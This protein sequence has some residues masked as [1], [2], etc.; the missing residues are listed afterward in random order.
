MM[1]AMI[2]VVMM[3]VND[4]GIDN[5]GEYKCGDNDDKGYEGDDVSVGG[6]VVMLVILHE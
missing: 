4:D 2:T 5:D 1:M 3:M 6:D